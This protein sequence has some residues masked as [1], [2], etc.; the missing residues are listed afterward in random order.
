MYQLFLEF[1]SPVGHALF[2][3]KNSVAFLYG[4]MISFT[5][6]K[7]DILELKGLLNVHDVHWAF[8]KSVPHLLYIIH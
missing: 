5:L 4:A 1:D 7:I 8:H 2:V 3:Q 6:R